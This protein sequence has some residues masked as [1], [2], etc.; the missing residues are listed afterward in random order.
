MALVR[1]GPGTS[2]VP[3]NIAIGVEAV[4]GNSSS[5]TAMSLST[6]HSVSRRP[7]SA[8][9][10]IGDDYEPLCV[11]IRLSIGTTSWFTTRWGDCC[12]T[13]QRVVEPPGWVMAC[14]LG[15]A[16]WSRFVDAR[17]RRCIDP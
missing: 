10:A 6:S 5:M 15:P 2:R 3:V 13:V 11:D 12:A 7:F 14:G 4:V 9:A 17:G 16:V 8:L 1:S